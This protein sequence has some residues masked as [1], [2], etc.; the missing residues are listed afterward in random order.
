MSSFNCVDISAQHNTTSVFCLYFTD[1]QKNKYLIPDTNGV[2]VAKKGLRF[3]A[4]LSK[5][6]LIAI[7]KEQY[8]LL[9][10]LVC[11]FK[12]H[13]LRVLLPLLYKYAYYVQ[14][15]DDFGVNSV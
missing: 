9:K 14:I 11:I 13:K 5:H 7:I 6:L 8:F 4:N 3:S 15:C 1:V 2:N 10:V 12:A